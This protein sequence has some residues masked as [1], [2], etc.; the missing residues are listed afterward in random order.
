MRGLQPG[1]REQ[2]DLPRVGR[3]RGADDLVAARLREGGEIVLDGV[4]VGGRAR[5]DLLGVLAEE[6]VVVAEVL[7]GGLLG[8][9][10]QPVV[11]GGPGAGLTVPARRRPRLAELRGARAELLGGPAALRPAVV[12]GGALERDVRVPA[13]QDRRAPPAPP[14]GGHPP[15]SLPQTPT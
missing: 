4:C 2:I 10:A 7:T 3:H 14:G 5:D 13:D 11:E 6:T 15:P 8:A 12:F 9:V 1:L